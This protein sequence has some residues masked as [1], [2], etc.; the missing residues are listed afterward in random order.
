MKLRRTNVRLLNERGQAQGVHFCKHPF[1][2]HARGHTGLTVSWYSGCITEAT[3]TL[4]QRFGTSAQAGAYIRGEV[5]RLQPLHTCWPHSAALAWGLE[6]VACGH[7]IHGS[8]YWCMVDR[9]IG[10]PRAQ[11]LPMNLR[12]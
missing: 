9:C 6:G 8:R 11:F 7:I 12:H 3:Y 2:V 5:I 1:L 10:E 4:L